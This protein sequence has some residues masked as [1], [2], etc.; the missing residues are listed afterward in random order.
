MRLFR[1]RGWGIGTLLSLAQ[2]AAAAVVDVGAAGGGG[3]ISAAVV[4]A[5]TVTG[6]AFA[7]SDDC[8]SGIDSGTVAAFLSSLGSSC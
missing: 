2:D 4:T 5:L 6:A 7:L 1:M 8:S 3:V